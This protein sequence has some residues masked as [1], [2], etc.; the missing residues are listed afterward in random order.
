MFFLQEAHCAAKVDHGMILSNCGNA[1]LVTRWTSPLR[2]KTME[3][4]ADRSSACWSL[5]PIRINTHAMIRTF[6]AVVLLAVALAQ[7]VQG[8]DFDKGFQ[9]YQHGDYATALREWTLLA[10]EGEGA[11]QFN[12]GHMYED[13]TGVERNDSEAMKWYNKA[14]EQG[15]AVAQST[16]GRK[17]YFGHGVPRDYGMAVKWHRLAAEQG[18]A[19]SQQSLGAAYQRGNGVPQDNAEAVRWFRM[20]AEQGYARAQNNMGFIYMKGIGI[21][22]DNA[23]AVRWFRMSAEQ[24]DTMAQSNLGVMYGTGLGVLQDFVQAHMWANLAAARGGKGGI[25]LRD[26]VAKDMTPAQI[27][28]AQKLAREC[29]ARDYKNCE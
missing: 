20:S 27:A 6:I 7:P 9:A 22:Q 21:P 3:G 12:L 13:G 16:L 24:G 2:I 14:A 11:A 1:S 4:I 23:E 10:E 28:E 19:N 29:L 8:Q 5:T 18:D 25:K 15:L 17:H 26:L